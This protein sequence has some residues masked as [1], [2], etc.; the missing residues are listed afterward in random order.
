MKK[1]NLGLAVL[2]LGAASTAFATPTG[3]IDFTGLLVDDTC[4][5]TVNGGTADG[6]ITLPTMNIASLTAANAVAGDTPF[7]ITLTG[8]GCEA[9]SKIA[10]P[11]F[12]SEPTKVNA[13]GRLINTATVDKADE[14]DIQL[15]TSNKTVI[16]LNKTANTQETT[17]AV[18]NGANTNEFKYFARYFATDTTTNGNITSS[19]SYSIFYK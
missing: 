3:K 10:T 2:T 6:S 9:S 18:A 11:Y 7:T 8:T 12:E 14:V 1:L 13:A 15:V 19:V 16:D 4:I 17:T 5:A